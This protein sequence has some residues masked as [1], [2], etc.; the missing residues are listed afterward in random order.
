MGT[1]LVFIGYFFANIVAQF[2][3]LAF[4]KLAGY[5]LML[6][7]LRR[8]RPYH[9]LF[10][11]CYAIGFLSLPF[12]AY[13]TYTALL[14]LGVPGSAVPA[15]LATAMEWCYFVFSIAFELLL[16]FAFGRLSQELG[17]TRTATPAFR[18]MIFVGLYSFIYF[19]AN[20]PVV[21]T[22]AAAKYF[23]LPLLLMR[24]LFLFLDL[25]LLFLCYRDIA[26]EE[27][28]QME[29]EKLP[30]PVQKEEKKHEK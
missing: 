25:W 7:G 29:L 13:Y 6:L 26:P 5:P 19:V 11:V 24:M 4:V 16:L 15:G 20:L 27:S 14:A 3:P 17:H 12:A 23:Y 8:L 1:G 18:N 2:S 21:A 9:P 30:E 28:E 10:R 22:S